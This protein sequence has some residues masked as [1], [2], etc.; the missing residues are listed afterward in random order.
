M[1][2]VL[3]CARQVV[4]SR[5][6]ALEHVV[7]HVVLAT[8]GHVARPVGSKVALAMV[9]VHGN[10]ASYLAFAAASFAAAILPALQA[11]YDAL[12]FCD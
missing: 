6:R 7:G 12:I 5:T 3:T 11:A 8:V 2:V 4:G 9:A 1:L 10:R